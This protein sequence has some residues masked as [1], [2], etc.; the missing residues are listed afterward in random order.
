MRAV[1]TPALVTGDHIRLPENA[2]EGPAEVIVLV[3]ESGEDAPAETTGGNLDDFLTSLQ[4]DHCFICSKEGI[5][6]FLQEV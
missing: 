1:K 4:L 5:D 6:E 3:P 2:S